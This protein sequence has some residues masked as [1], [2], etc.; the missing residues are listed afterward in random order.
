LVNKR[1]AE[2]ELKTSSEAAVDA[3][4]ALVQLLELDVQAMAMSALRVGLA[5]A[6]LGKMEEELKLGN[7]PQTTV[8]QTLSGLKVMEFNNASARAT[9][10]ARWSE[11]AS[12]VGADPVL[13]QLP[14]RHD[15]EKR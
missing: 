12:L 15:S 14:A 13:T 1:A 3:A 2:L 8:D 11:F 5:S 10:L 7:V 4:Q 6:Q 9:F